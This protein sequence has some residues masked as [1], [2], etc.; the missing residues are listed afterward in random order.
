MAWGVRSRKQKKEYLQ[1]CEDNSEEESIKTYKSVL[2]VPIDKNNWFIVC[3]F[4]AQLDDSKGER[5]PKEQTVFCTP[6]K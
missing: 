3:A 2:P 4:I 6:H 1:G 5:V